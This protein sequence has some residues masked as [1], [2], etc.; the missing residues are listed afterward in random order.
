METEADL[1]SFLLTDSKSN[2]V[3]S[4]EPFESLFMNAVLEELT[5]TS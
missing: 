1:L 3:A 5:G 2:A 4:I